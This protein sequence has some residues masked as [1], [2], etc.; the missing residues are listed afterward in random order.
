MRDNNKQINQ[1]AWDLMEFGVDP[2][3]AYEYAYDSSENPDVYSFVE[4]VIGIPILIVMIVM[5][6]PEI[7]WEYLKKLW[8]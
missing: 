3:G 7:I 8:S 2:W 6:L 5:V 1:E 4:A